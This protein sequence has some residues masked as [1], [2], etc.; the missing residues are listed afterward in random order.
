RIVPDGHRH[1]VLLLYAP[2]RLTPGGERSYLAAE[3]VLV[4]RLGIRRALR[5][6]HFSPLYLP[7]TSEQRCH[8]GQVV[9][10]IGSHYQRLSRNVLTHPKRNYALVHHG[11]R[12][13]CGTD[14]L[15]WTHH[16]I[17]SMN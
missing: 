5:P 1:G 10:R 12:R 16:A 7:R 2:G 14:S 11:Y 17:T 6:R 9:W 3:P 8:S 13:R 15:Y 4:R